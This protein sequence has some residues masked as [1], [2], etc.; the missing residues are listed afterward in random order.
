M[1]RITYKAGG[2]S[3]LDLRRTPRCGFSMAPV[4]PGTLTAD[5]RKLEHDNPPNQH[6]TGEGEST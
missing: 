6:P 5:A 4:Q 3:P 1:Q 2:L